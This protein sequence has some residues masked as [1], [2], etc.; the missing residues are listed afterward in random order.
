MKRP[1]GRGSGFGIRWTGM[2]K[3]LIKERLLQ[4]LDDGRLSRGERKALG[5][6]AAEANVAEH[7][8]W[9]QQAFAIVRERLPEAS[10]SEADELLG[11]LEGVTKLVLGARQDDSSA[12]SEA[13]FSPGSGPRKR[14]AGLIG[15]AKQSV[16]ICV[17]TIS[18]DRLVE[19]IVAAH[20]RGIRVRIIS[21][22]DKSEDRGSD[23]ERLSRA[24]IP[25]CYDASRHHMHHKYAVFDRRWLLTGSYNWTR[26]AAEYNR[27]N[28]VI[29]SEEGLVQKFGENFDELWAQLQGHAQG[30]RS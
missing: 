30:R 22:D 1:G 28:V 18:D 23:V 14:I 26:S 21:D 29:T 8:L 27:E 20:R 4:T 24:G 25:V 6:L 10:Q 17:F 7:H 12:A 16:D 15:E 5:A 13:L 3:E 2:S 19:P 9:R 11:W